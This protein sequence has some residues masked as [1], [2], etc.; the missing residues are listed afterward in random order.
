M[1]T[2]STYRQPNRYSVIRRKQEQ[3]SVALAWLTVIGMLV[4]FVSVP[5]VWDY[6]SPDSL[7]C[8]VFGTVHGVRA[9]CY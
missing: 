4:V 3:R 1:A 7:E 8:A 6:V 9:I 2:R 5:L